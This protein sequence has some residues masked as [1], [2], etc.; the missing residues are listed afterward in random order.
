MGLR[1]I[2]TCW[3]LMLIRVN[4]AVTTEQSLVALGDGLDF[5]DGFTDDIAVD[6]QIV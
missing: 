1:I 4:R 5:A 3:A 2:C 6:Y